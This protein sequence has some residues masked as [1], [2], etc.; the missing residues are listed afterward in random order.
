[1]STSQQGV[2]GTSHHYLVVPRTL[3]FVTH[4][5]DVLLIR[6]S[7]EKRI[8]PNLYNGIG[9]HVEPNED[10]YSAARREIRE[11]TG[12]AVRDLRLRGMVNIQGGS[13][14][15]GVLLFVFTACATGRGVRPSAEGTPVWV[16]RDRADT[17]ELVEDLRVLLP[18]VLTMGPDDPPFSAHYW[19]DEQDRLQIR[20]AR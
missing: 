12:L 3:A 9:G 14:D 13:Q 18:R 19:Y 5:D 16:Q 20:F 4:G 15:P 7:P 2:T 6:G 17:V 11:E 8:W 10:I 1:V